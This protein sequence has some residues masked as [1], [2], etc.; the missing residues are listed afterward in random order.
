MT[1]K[2]SVQKQAQENLHFCLEG[3][4]ELQVNIQYIKISF[5]QIHTTKFKGVKTLKFHFYNS[6]Q[7][8]YIALGAEITN[9]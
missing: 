9:P 7:H 6:G 3:G 1:G 5:R 2:L 4:F 8:V